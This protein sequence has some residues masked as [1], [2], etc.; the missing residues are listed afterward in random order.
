MNRPTVTLASKVL[1]RCMLLSALT[2][3]ACSVDLSG[4][5]EALCNEGLC[6]SGGGVGGD[7]NPALTIAGSVFV[8]GYAVAQGQA[9]VQ[10]ISFDGYPAPSEPLSVNSAG[11]Y[12]QSFYG[13]VAS[14]VCGWSAQARL[15]D[16]RMSAVVPLFEEPLT[17][18]SGSLDAVDF[19]FPAS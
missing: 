14:A 1:A 13:D 9:E 11:M 16:G 2:T 8:G 15:M 19:H 6:T 17:S 3:T 5:D 12:T 18:C 7:S 4:L 10:L